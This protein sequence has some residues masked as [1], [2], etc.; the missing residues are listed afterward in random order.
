[1]GP[2]PRRAKRPGTVTRG[3]WTKRLED[4]DRTQKSSRR[5]FVAKRARIPVSQIVNTFATIRLPTNLQVV[6]AMVRWTEIASREKLKFCFV[7]MVALSLASEQPPLGVVTEIEVL[8]SSHGTALDDR[9]NVRS[10]WEET[11]ETTQ[12]S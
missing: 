8:V 7:G 1:M 2:A 3:R 5:P 9:Y 10:L 11:C 4:V 6:T 12:M